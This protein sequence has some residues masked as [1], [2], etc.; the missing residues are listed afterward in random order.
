MSSSSLDDSSDLSSLIPEDLQ[1]PYRFVTVTRGCGCSLGELGNRYANPAVLKQNAIL[2]A[3]LVDDTRHMQ[4][5]RCKM[6][7]DIWL[8]SAAEIVTENSNKGSYLEC[9][10]VFPTTELQTDRPI[11]DPA[12]LFEVELY[13][14]GPLAY[15]SPRMLTDNV[16]LLDDDAVRIPAE[17]KLAVRGDA[18]LPSYSGDSLDFIAVAR[19]AGEAFQAGLKAVLCSD[20]CVL[21]E[22]KCNGC[23]GAPG[24]QWS[25]V[26]DSAKEKEGKHCSRE[27]QVVNGICKEPS[28]F[29]ESIAKLF[30]RVPPARVSLLYVPPPLDP[31]RFEVGNR[32]TRSRCDD[33][34]K[35]FSEL[36]GSSAEPATLP[37]FEDRFGELKTGTTATLTDKMR[38]RMKHMYEK[39][40]DFQAVIIITPVPCEDATKTVRL[41]VNPEDGR[42][43]EQCE[44]T[45][46]GMPLV[47]YAVVLDFRDHEEAGLQPNEEAK[48]K[49]LNEFGFVTMGR[50]H[51]WRDDSWN[52]NFGRG[53]LGLVTFSGDMTDWF[54][55]KRSLRQTIFVQDDPR[56]TTVSAKELRC[57][58]RGH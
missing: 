32:G 48:F 7:L 14:E 8:S 19:P 50:S 29:K 54:T 9:E 3:P 26:A 27:C 28:S 52:V 24:S 31:S 46:T 25:C 49:E 40:C 22:D 4:D 42:V 34:N 45:G 18:A 58:A 35:A 17:L 15:A 41:Q 6:R 57:T 30:G 37:A 39:T 38:Q 13:S 33:R 23:S 55:S 47:R 43:R 36:F 11:F 21:V 20:L 56:V 16:Y 2:W 53:L 10:V 5:M 44:A 1:Q 12:D 51:L